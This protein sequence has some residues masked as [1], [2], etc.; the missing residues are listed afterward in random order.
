MWKYVIWD[1]NHCFLYKL[2]CPS[3]TFLQHVLERCTKP[4]YLQ[5]LRGEFH[6]LTQNLMSHRHDDD[7][8]YILLWHNI[9]G[10]LERAVWC[11]RTTSSLNCNIFSSRP[12]PSN[13]FPFTINLKLLMLSGNL[14][15]H[16][17]PNKSV[18]K[19]LNW[20]QDLSTAAGVLARPPQKHSLKSGHVKILD[21]PK[22]T[23]DG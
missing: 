10:G 11:A 5:N 13:A 14:L 1:A 16:V 8:K 18:A 23:H 6:I 22:F 7:E 12:T 20:Y 2:R 17:D 3:D 9:K 4:A 21:R 19:W 15:Q